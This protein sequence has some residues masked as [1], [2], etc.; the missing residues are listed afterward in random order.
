MSV[1]EIYIPFV[2][3]SSIFYKTQPPTIISPLITPF[4]TEHLSCYGIE[5][6]TIKVRSFLLFKV[7]IITKSRS[8]TI[9]YPLNLK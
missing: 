8:Y 9:N 4:T 7:E 6:D 5:V 2:V 1:H 3:F